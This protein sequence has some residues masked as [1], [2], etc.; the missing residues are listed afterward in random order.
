[1]RTAIAIACAILP[2]G[3][4]QLL[5]SDTYHFDGVETPDSGYDAGMADR[6]SGGAEASDGD[7]NACKLSA[8]PERN[9]TRD[10]G[11]TVEL[12]YVMNNIDL[13]DVPG[14]DG[15]PGYRR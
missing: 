12:V 10:L 4:R 11:G 5:S 8:P 2:L 3:C 14:K 9:T 15:V 13:G 6:S 7:A 1:M